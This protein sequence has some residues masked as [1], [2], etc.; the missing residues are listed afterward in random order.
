MKRVPAPVVLV[1]ALLV[2]AICVRLGFWQLSRLHEKQALNARLV[3]ALAAPPR[4]PEAADSLAEA[5]SDALRRGRFTARGRYDE[6]R[7]FLLMG[8]AK[9][10][11]PGVG[12]V[13]PLLPADGGPALLVDRGWIPSYD[14]ATAQPER[15]PA[16]GERTVTGLAEPLARGGP[17]TRRTRYFRV[18]IDSLE[19]WSTPRLDAD[20]V[21]ARLPYRVRPWVLRALPD[22]AD[23]LEV[24]QA[25]E[26]GPFAGPLRMAPRPYDEGMHRSYAGQWFAFAA[27]T[28]IG[29]I[30]LVLKGRANPAT[31][32]GG[33]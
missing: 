28:L 11:E 30:V 25:A 27:I 21:A 1:L 17:G 2:A 13:T 22:A 23:S 6:T 32:K 8:R 24:L 26:S 18:E 31:G 14:A 20:S 19:V 3:S 15:F 12:V 16:P 5:G 4:A 7:Q 10:G 29:S 9:D 33:G